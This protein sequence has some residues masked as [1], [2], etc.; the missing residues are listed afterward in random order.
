MFVEF[1]NAFKDEKDEGV[2]RKFHVSTGLHETSSGIISKCG[3][4][5]SH[6]FVADGQQLQRGAFI[7]K[8]ETDKEYT[9]HIY[10]Q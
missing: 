10:V 8:I 7:L 5:T 6:A 3:D 9:S 2:S 4:S 1:V